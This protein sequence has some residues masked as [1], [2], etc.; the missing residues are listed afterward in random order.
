MTVIVCHLW[1]HEINFTI[2]SVHLKILCHGLPPA[3]H[4]RIILDS[5][6]S[7]ARSLGFCFYDF[8]LLAGLLKKLQLNFWKHSAL[9]NNLIDFGGVL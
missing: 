3:D 9:V 2:I 4:P 8:S 6:I 1:L 7:F 5:L